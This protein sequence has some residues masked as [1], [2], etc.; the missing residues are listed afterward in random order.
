MPLHVDVDRSF[1]VGE[2][3]FASISADGEW[4]VVFEDDGVTGYFYASSWDDAGEGD[5]KS[6]LDALHVYNV[7]DVP[8]LA[9]TKRLEI[10]WN[11]AGTA[12][13]LRLDG[14]PHAFFDF[15]ASRAGCR[16]GFP[17]R[18]ADSPFVRADGLDAA[19]ASTFA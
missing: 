9:S 11:D 10:V 14:E 7:A 18:L 4:A 5:F 19:I 6:L 2:A 17:P 13:M 3:W 8:K 12:A 15:A 1:T 16:T